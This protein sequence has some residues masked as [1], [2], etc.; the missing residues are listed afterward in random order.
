[1]SRFRDAFLVC[2]LAVA[3]GACAGVH[4][5]SDE[6]KRELTS[7]FGTGEVY[8]YIDSLSQQLVESPYVNK[9]FTEQ[10]PPKVAFQ[11]KNKTD[12][13]LPVGRIHEKIETNLVNSGKF[14]VIDQETKADRMGFLLEQQG[15]MFDPTQAA[16]LGKLLGVHFILQG[17]FDYVKDPQGRET[18]SEYALTFKLVECKT[19]AIRWKGDEV[20]SKSSK[21][22]A[23]RG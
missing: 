19:G 18:R 10:D 23:F 16:E 14:L 20:V 22:G 4:E 3:L 8:R 11:F 17:N 2:S 5:M 15:D 21:R 6:E 13:E 9:N 12:I 1:M 7:N